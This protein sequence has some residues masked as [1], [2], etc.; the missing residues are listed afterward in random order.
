MGDIQYEH[1]NANNPVL[2]ISEDPTNPDN[3][4]VSRLPLAVS[5]PKNTVSS[6]EGTTETPG[7]ASEE[8]SET[9][10]EEATEDEEN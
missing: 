3:V 7:V 10:E 2:V 4:L 5:V 6:S 1:G 8:A 9:P